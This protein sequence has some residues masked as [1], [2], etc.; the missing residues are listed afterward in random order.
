MSRVVHE[1]YCTS[2]GKYF[3]VKL[4]IAL[5]GNYR[6]HCPSCQHVHYR[7]LI[8]GEITDTRFPDNHESILIEDIYPMK[9]SCRD[10]QK[11]TAMVTAGNPAP[12]AFLARLW[13]DRYS[14]RI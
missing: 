7:V 11:E 12:E 14:E 1:F 2:C 5:N 10:F 3:D 6:I 4:N 9:S 8:K 13:H